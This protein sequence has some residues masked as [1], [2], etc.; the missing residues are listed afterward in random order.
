MTYR[1]KHP[2]F[3][4]VCLLHPQ[5]KGLT[6][7]K[8]NKKQLLQLAWQV[9]FCW[10]AVILQWLLMLIVYLFCCG[11]EE[12]KNRYIYILFPLKCH[13]VLAIWLKDSF[14]SYIYFNLLGTN[15]HYYY[16]SDS[17]WKIWLVESIQ[18]IHNSLWTWHNKCNICYRY[19]IYHV[20]FNVCL[21]TK[22][23]G[24]FSS[25]TEWLNFFCLLFN[26]CIIKQLLNYQNLGRFPFGQKFRKFR[27]GA[28]WKT[29]FRFA[30][31]ENSQK[32][33]NYRDYLLSSSTFSG[34]FPA[35]RIEKTFSI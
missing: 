9:P 2:H 7:T 16:T 34:N 32:K 28:K 35:G 31:P 11:M 23:L 19:C 13:V 27:F 21:V 6:Q 12:L 26:K 29:F 24:V 33:W 10:S 1:R 15:I 22:P 5:V 3:T 20:K 30:R 17:L 25:E 18:S 8:I 14:I 4:V